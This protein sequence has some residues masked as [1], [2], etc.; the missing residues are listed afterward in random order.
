LI[1]PRGFTVKARVVALALV[2]L[3]ALLSGCG[4]DQSADKLA[5]KAQPR[6]SAAKGADLPANFP[7]DVPMPRAATLQL[8]MSQGGKT[9]VQL[10]TPDSVA[11]A[12]KF[13]LAALQEGGWQIE[14]TDKTPEMFVISAKKGKLHCGAT[15]SRD[16]KRTLVRLTVTEGTS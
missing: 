1:P 6:V 10:Y 5:G 3:V 16:G 4:R 7:S 15:V 8:T 11:D 14:S 9:L 12:G 13:Y 2:L